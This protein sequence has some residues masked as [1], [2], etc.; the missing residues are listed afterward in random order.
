MPAN[1]IRTAPGHHLMLTTSGVGMLRC[2]FVG[3]DGNL[4]SGALLPPAKETDAFIDHVWLP[5]MVGGLPHKMVVLTDPDHHQH[6]HAHTGGGGLGSGLGPGG[7]NASAMSLGGGDSLMSLSASQMGS[8]DGSHAPP[9]A[10]RRQQLLVFEGSDVP[11]ARCGLDP[12][13]VVMLSCHLATMPSFQCATMPSFHC[14]VLSCH[15]MP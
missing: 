13:H 6:H 9:P 15:A 11:G 12:H 10:F 8:K 3:T 14:A 4:R 1:R 5:P 2:W 7:H